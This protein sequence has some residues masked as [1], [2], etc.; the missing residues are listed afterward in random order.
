M[1]PCSTRTAPRGPSSLALCFEFFPSFKRGEELA[2]DCGMARRESSALAGV[3]GEDRAVLEL[4]ADRLL[5]GLERGD[6]L[7]QRFEF[8]LIFERELRSSLRIAAGGAVLRPG[9]ARR[10]FRRAFP[11][12]FLGKPVG[13]LALRLPVGEATDV[14]SPPSLAFRSDHRCDDVV[15]K[16]PIVADEHD[17]PIV[18]IEELLKQLKR[19]N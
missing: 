6:R 12:G 18:I 15:E 7:R 16:R 19:R 14:F 8:T 17:R 9:I 10:S 2:V 1:P 5:L 3:F 13:P 11:G 4:R